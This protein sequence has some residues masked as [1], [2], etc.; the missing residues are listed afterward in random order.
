MGRAGV[1]APNGIGIT[2]SQVV[3]GGGLN[4]NR[5]DVMKTSYQDVYNKGTQ[6]NPAHAHR[7][8]NQETNV[9]AQNVAF[10]KGHD[11]NAARKYD[12]NIVNNGPGPM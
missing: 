9:G 4:P 6:G 12:Y 10:V 5:P 2:Y 3:L 7:F 11:F 8:I 1:Q